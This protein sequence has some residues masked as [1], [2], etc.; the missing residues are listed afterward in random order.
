[1]IKRFNFNYIFSF[2]IIKIE[3]IKCKLKHLKYISMENIFMSTSNQK[4]YNDII[5][6]Y[7][8]NE[9]ILSEKHYLLSDLLLK[10]SLDK[11][12]KTAIKNELK[13]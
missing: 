9:I 7:N 8:N 4:I 12:L 10:S 2:R 3:F 5:S 13:K 11:L 6:L 1:M